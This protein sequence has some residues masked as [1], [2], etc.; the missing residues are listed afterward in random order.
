M[1]QQGP[2]RLPAKAPAYGPHSEHLQPSCTLGNFYS[3][4][5]RCCCPMTQHR[6][7]WN[8][9]GWRTFCRAT[10]RKGLRTMVHSS[11]ERPLLAQRSNWL[12]QRGG[13]LTEHCG[14]KWLPKTCKFTADTPP[15]LLDVGFLM[16]EDETLCARKWTSPSDACSSAA[17]VGPQLDQ[18]A[19][20]RPRI[21]GL[22]E[23]NI[24]WT[25]PAG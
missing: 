7:V 6:T 2:A 10:A 4:M 25:G 11:P 18:P 23:R 13:A 20:N 16:N 22:L 14:F 9:P 24:V 15:T 17:A 1:Q 19:D 3:I 5:Q 21:T 8:I 12:Q